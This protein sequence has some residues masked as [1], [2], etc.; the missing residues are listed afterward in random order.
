MGGHDYQE[1]VQGRGR[2]FTGGVQGRGRQFTPFPRQGLGGGTRWGVRNKLRD[3][4]I[5]F[6]QGHV[7]RMLF[8]SSNL[9]MS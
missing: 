3:K 8:L 1:Q 5:I 7:A 4:S 2:Q 9:G 6:I